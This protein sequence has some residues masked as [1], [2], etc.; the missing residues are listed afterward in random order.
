M[1]E[2]RP[3]D[4]LDRFEEDGQPFEAYVK[5]DPVR[6]RSGRTA[7]AFLPVGEFTEGEWSVAQATFD[8]AALWFGL[9]TRLLPRAKLPDDDRYRRVRRFAQCPK[10]VTQYL[11]R[12]FLDG[13]LLTRVPKDAVLLAAVTMGDLYPEDN[14][15][16]VFGQATFSR[17]VAVYSLARYFPEFR[18]EKV[19]EES[20]T[21]ALRRSL[22]L[23]TH[24]VGHCF[25]LR[26]CVEFECNMNGSNSLEES[27]RRPLPLCP[28][29][30]RKLQWNRGFDVLDRY[31]AL[32]DFYEAHDL[33]PEAVWTKARIARI[34]AVR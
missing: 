20:R 6:A 16:Y 5:G 18:G 3:G 33:D 7:L 28:S 23:V 32:V 29:C 1:G 30:L 34:E 26:H 12:W 4:W 17:R 9:E 2:P 24:E 14:W 21:Q 8:F 10:P 22:K 11:T 27:D 25:G 15:N 13:Y 19:T 31:R